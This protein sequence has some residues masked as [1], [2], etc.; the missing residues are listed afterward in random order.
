MAASARAASQAA[1]PAK[2]GGGGGELLHGEG[3]L[4]V[5]QA[6]V[7]Q[8]S[9]TQPLQESPAEATIKAWILR[10]TVIALSTW[11]CTEAK[12]A[13]TNCHT[14]QQGATGDHDE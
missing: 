3:Q 11:K 6:S 1:E 7:E 5:M 14:A 9:I 13:D 4:Q 8:A 10:L 2:R 12:S